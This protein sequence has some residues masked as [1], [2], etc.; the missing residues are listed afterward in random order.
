MESSNHPICDARSRVSRNIRVRALKLARS[1]AVP[2]MDV[3]DFEQHLRLRLVKCNDRFDPERASYDTYADRVLG[4]CVASLAEPTDRLCAERLWIDINGPL[5]GAKDGEP[6]RLSDA[7][8]ENAALFASPTCQ[9]D[10]I[11][12]LKLDVQHM[13]SML[14][15]ASQSVAA[16]L[17]EMSPTEAARELRVHRSTV[18]AH[19]NALRKAALDLGLDTYVAR[20]RHF[21]ASAGM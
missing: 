5:P 16:A 2:G 19:L 11:I 8:S 12:G 1:G 3:D 17:T 20:P 9:P 7:L 14:T 4:N 13:L 6:L 10:E 15:T 21:R 18:Y